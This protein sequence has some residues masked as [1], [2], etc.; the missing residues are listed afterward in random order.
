M[1]PTTARGAVS[2]AWAVGVC[3]F[4]FAGDLVGVPATYFATQSFF[5]LGPKAPSEE[6]HLAN[7]A[8]R[9]LFPG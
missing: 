7:I 3:S 9:S 4:P 2:L 8:R 6:F 5:I 1:F